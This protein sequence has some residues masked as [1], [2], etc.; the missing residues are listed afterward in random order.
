MPEQLLH[1]LSGSF[2]IRLAIDLLSIW[3]LVRFIYFTTYRTRDLF[4]T[5]II[6][7]LVIFLISFALNRTELSMGAAFGL[8][9][10]FSMLRYRTEDISIKDMTYLFLSIALGV[11]TAVSN[12]GWYLQL[13]ISGVIL[14][15]TWLLESQWL[16]RKESS[17]LV[18][19]DKI[20]LVHRN[21][22][23]ALITDLKERTGLP[24]HRVQVQK[25]DLLHDSAHLRIFY[26]EV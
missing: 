13:A 10:V 8:F 14:G 6:F 16:Y 5:F 1:Q 4:F 25:I 12:G 17:K 26:Y 20:E 21:Q 9:A 18:F 15:A 3:I 7:N 19:Y 24:V 22:E 11:L 2:L 23:D